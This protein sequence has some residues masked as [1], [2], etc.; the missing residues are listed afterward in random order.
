VTFSAL[1]GAVENSALARGK[2][3]NCLGDK[4][5]L[6]WNENW[7]PRI[8]QEEVNGSQGCE[9]SRDFKVEARGDHQDDSFKEVQEAIRGLSILQVQLRFAPL[10]IETRQLF[11]PDHGNI[12]DYLPKDL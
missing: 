4:D 9:T 10:P 1:E 5:L 8:V 11:L 2:V 7:Q 12:E 3:L 6:S